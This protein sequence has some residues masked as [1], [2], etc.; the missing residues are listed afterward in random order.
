MEYPI[1]KPRAVIF[2]VYATLL[3]VGPPPADAEARWNRLFEELLDA[4]PSL[5]RTEFFVRT[6]QVIARRHAAARACGIQWPEIQWPSIVAEVLPDLAHLPARKFDEF[7][8]LQM[9]IGRTLRLA[10][11]AGECLRQLHERG[12]VLGIASNSQDYT[13]R[14][15]GEALKGAGLTL[16]IFDAHLCVWSFQHGF[17]KPDPHIFQIITARLEGRGIGPGETL[18][19]GDRLDNDIQPARAHG[20]QTWQLAPASQG[21]GMTSGEFRQLLAA[22]V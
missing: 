3:Q 15:L 12:L 14:E 17:S 16:S 1:V 2:D 10:D 19:V 18:M 22:L 21:D 5:S 11:H 7:I 8:F 6:N 13:L 4:R 9:Q 20:W